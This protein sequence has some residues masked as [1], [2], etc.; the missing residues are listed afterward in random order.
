[1]VYHWLLVV[2]HRM[3]MSDRLF[4]L[5]YSFQK[6]RFLSRTLRSLSRD[7]QSSCQMILSC[8]SSSLLL[9][10]R[11]SNEIGNFFIGSSHEIKKGVIL[12][13]TTPLLLN[14]LFHILSYVIPLTEDT[15]TAYYLQPAAWE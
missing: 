2:R 8:T 14:H 12:N 4:F 10:L 1:M 9:L 11:K 13:R 5:R 6:F 15:G 7:R 3:Y